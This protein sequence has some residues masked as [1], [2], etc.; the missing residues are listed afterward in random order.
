M[1]TADQAGQWLLLG[2]SIQ[3][4]GS[5]KWGNVQ[6]ERGQHWAG[7]DA[8]K[9]GAPRVESSK[10][11]Q[12]RIFMIICL[13]YPRLQGNPRVAQ[14]K[15]C[16][17]VWRNKSQKRLDMVPIICCLI[18]VAQ[19]LW[20]VGIANYLLAHYKRCYWM[21]SWLASMFIELP[22]TYLP[23]SNATVPVEYATS[24][25]YLSGNNTNGLTFE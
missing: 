12:A 7:W 11:Y 1:E 5:C 4:P 15:D 2:Q 24:Y 3:W 6:L 25:A 13:A 9:G 10:T 22:Y 17:V 18:L 23:E 21:A 14:S 20:W 8:I 19:C 16:Y